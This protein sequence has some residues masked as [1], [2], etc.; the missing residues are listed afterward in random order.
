MAQ[1]QSR[2]RARENTQTY[3]DSVPEGQRTYIQCGR[4]FMEDDRAAITTDMKEQIEAIDAEL[5]KMEKAA[6]ELE[7]RFDKAK[8]EL[9]DCL[10]AK[11]LS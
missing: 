6:K 7:E 11:Q 8:K 2:K 10:G 3:L 9:E 4:A 5:P 1:K